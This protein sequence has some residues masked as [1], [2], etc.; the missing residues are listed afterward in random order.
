MLSFTRFILSL[1]IISNT[2]LLAGCGLKP[3]H[4]TPTQ[5]Y[6]LNPTIP[7][8][9]AKPSQL[10]LLVE[11][12]K[13]N[14]AFDTTQM[15]YVN[16]PYQLAYF[17]YNQWADTPAQMLHPLLVEALQNTNHFHAVIG[18]A[19]STK[20]DMVLST[21]MLE[22]QQVFLQQPSQIQLSVRIQLVDN[23]SH[24]VI[25]IKQLTITEPATENNPYSGV[26]AANKATEK[27]LQQISEFCVVNTSQLTTQ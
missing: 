27:L 21:R 25:A 5:T 11:T 23:N 1:F 9:K 12:P 14:P 7:T 16:K 18:N 13:A 3:I 6:I 10:T 26:M 2:F 8:I 17:S 22:L 15:A 19:N 4:I 24:R 20:Y